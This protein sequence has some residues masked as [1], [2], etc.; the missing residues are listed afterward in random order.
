MPAAANFFPIF[1]SATDC[2]PKSALLDRPQQKFYILSSRATSINYYIKTAQPYQGQ[3]EVLLLTSAI[4]FHCRMKSK[5]PLH[6][7]IKRHAAIQL[8]AGS[9]VD[10]ERK[11]NPTPT[12]SKPPLRTALI[13]PSDSASPC[14][15]RF[16]YFWRSNVNTAVPAQEV[17]V[18]PP[19]LPGRAGT[20]TP[21]Q[22]PRTPE[23][24]RFF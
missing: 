18:D 16:F 15:N 12:K 11:I 8:H 21:P 23:S 17:R 22:R 9:L 19:R 7:A 24:N 13:S 4:E 1:Q 5:R 14:H 2:I 10:H 20:G 6:A 3:E